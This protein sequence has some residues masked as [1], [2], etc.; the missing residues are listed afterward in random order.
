MSTAE[1]SPSANRYKSNK[2]DL[3][4]TSAVRNQIIASSSNKEVS[5]SMAKDLPRNVK[6]ATLFK[7]KAAFRS[8]SSLH[9]IYPM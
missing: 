3:N 6:I 7:I 1:N 5:R 2:P 8:K 9:A 4:M